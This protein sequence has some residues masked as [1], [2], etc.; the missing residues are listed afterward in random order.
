MLCSVNQEVGGGDLDYVS[1]FHLHLFRALAASCVLYNR[2][3]HS[4]GFLFVTLKSAFTSLFHVLHLLVFFSLTNSPVILRGKYGQP[5]TNSRKR[6]VNGFSLKM[7]CLITYQKPPK[8]PAW[9][10]VEKR[11]FV[12]AVD[13]CI[14]HCMETRLIISRPNAYEDTA[15]IITIIHHKDET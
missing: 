2:T 7:Y 10:Q 4:Q 12:G 3:E 15:Q 1:C 8:I 5:G 14:F 9:Q 6:N 13:R 11:D